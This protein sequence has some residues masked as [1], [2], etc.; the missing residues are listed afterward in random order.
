MNIVENGIDSF[1]KAV[2]LL[3]N[4]DYQDYKKNESELK[5][6]IIS[7]HHSIE[8]LFKYILREE[9][10]Y[11][12][13]EDI[14]LVC[15]ELLNNSLNG[16]KTDF[17]KFKTIT[18]IEAVN[19]VLLLED[20][21]EI[22]ISKEKYN[23]FEMLN[24]WR[25]QLTHYEIDFKTEEI[26]HKIATLLPI[27]HDIYLKKI[28]DFN[29][30]L[31]RFYYQYSDINKNLYKK[32]EVGDIDY[33]NELCLLMCKFTEARNRVEYLDN[34]KEKIQA[35]YNNKG[36]EGMY[37]SHYKC[38]FCGKQLFIRKGCLFRDLST[39]IFY[40]ECEYCNI[41]ISKY[42]AAMIEV[43]FGY[44][45]EGR[46]HILCD[47]KDPK[48][49]FY[50]T[51]K[52]VFDDMYN[53]QNEVEKYNTINVDKIEDISTFEKIYDENR[54]LLDNAILYSFQDC[55]LGSGEWEI[56]NNINIEQNVLRMYR[57]SEINKWFTN[58]NGMKYKIS[59]I[60]TNKKR[61][62]IY[63][64]AKIFDLRLLEYYE[65]FDDAYNNL[66]QHAKNI[67]K[68]LN[69]DLSTLK[70][71]MKTKTGFGNDYENPHTQEKEWIDFYFNIQYEFDIEIF[72]I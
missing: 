14:T 69:G 68:L 27:L 28:P 19:R 46:E 38:P 48:G 70:S 60:E 63:L 43:I 8:V 32:I 9:N 41:N 53:N 34:N 18:F 52:T 4:I 29:N 21:K 33:F 13:Y 7:L 35:L 55:I 37:D 66:I 50:E 57:E 54:A 36:K 5:E 45:L 23:C 17:Y 12:I 51:L 64:D 15:K 20:L 31:Y 30:T 25:N 71:N 10:K 40:G 65:E 39:I 44:I 42:E 26:E 72:D 67:K 1:E 59:K 3:M 58:N 6:I 62:N 49:Y 47:L 56:T 11:L 16:T 2:S 61:I 24:K 22:K